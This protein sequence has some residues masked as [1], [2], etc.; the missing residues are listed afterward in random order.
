MNARRLIP[1][2][3]A[4]GLV[5]GCA[6]PTTT[7]SL[8]QED[9]LFK[10]TQLF[11]DG[12]EIYRAEY[13]HYDLF[14]ALTSPPPEYMKSGTAPVLLLKQQHFITDEAK[15]IVRESST[16]TVDELKA[17]LRDHWDA[18]VDGV[19]DKGQNLEDLLR[20]L[21]SMSLNI[22][23]FVVPFQKSGKSL[24]DYTKDVEAAQ[25]ASPYQVQAAPAVAAAKLAW[26]ILKSGRPIVDL[27]GLDSKIYNTA[28][29][30]WDNYSG[31]KQ[32]DKTL[33]M[34][35]KNLYGVS[36]VNVSAKRRLFYGATHNTLNGNYVPSISVA[37]DKVSVSWFLN[38]DAN[39]TLT[40]PVNIGG[41]TPQNP[42]NPRSVMDVSFRTSSIFQ[43]VTDTF[44]FPFSGKD[45][46]EN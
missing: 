25:G 7:N 21:K 41:T 1:L 9:G 33:T 4:L 46:W 14:D 31:A 29:T 8:P 6:T 30:N 37:F 38:L 12:K 42:I 40:Q 35:K 44:S 34:V 26:E 43:N 27:G 18:H 13:A 23:D 2:M 20:Y 36:L 11:L 17:F 32:S 3:L 10:E 24:S 28:D 39:V 15:S 19:D 5:G 16:L 45:G 22:E